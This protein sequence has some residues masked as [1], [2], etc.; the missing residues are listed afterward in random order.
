MPS[1][2]FFFG[3]IAVALA[4]WVSLAAQ[5][6]SSQPTL[7]DLETRARQD[8]NDANA[9]YVLALRYWDLSRYDDAEHELRQAIV[10]DPHDAQAF[11]A[12]SY[13][14]YARR[15]KPVLHQAMDANPRDPGA[16]YVLSTVEQQLNKPA[17]ARAALTRF[18]ALAPSKDTRIADAKDR[19]AKLP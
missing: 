9:H 8:S 14:P 3:G 7:A 5:A 17:D 1:R 10:V 12:L 6:K 2:S 4:G 18:L 19:L 11:F 16:P 15:P 13:L